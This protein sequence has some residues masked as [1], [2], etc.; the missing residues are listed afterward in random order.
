MCVLLRMKWVASLLKVPITQ[1]WNKAKVQYV[2]LGFSLKKKK[3]VSR[4]HGCEG[5]PE[6][7]AC[8]FTV[9]Y[10]DSSVRQFFQTELAPGDVYLYKCFESMPRWLVTYAWVCRQ[11]LLNE[12]AKS[13]KESA[14]TS[15]LPPKNRIL[16]YEKNRAPFYWFSKWQGIH[17]HSLGVAEKGLV[18]H[19]F[20]LGLVILCTTEGEGQWGAMLYCGILQLQVFVREHVVREHAC[21]SS[22]RHLSTSTFPLVPSH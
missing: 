1:G 14:S 15:L 13:R 5:K 7:V 12:A 16:L 11:P 6:N 18:P 21:P 17:Y 22:P 2:Y 9:Q 4:P 8:I 19:C 3:K 10:S 20:E